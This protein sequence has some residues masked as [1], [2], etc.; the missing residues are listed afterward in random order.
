MKYFKNRIFLTAVFC[1]VILSL[2]LA[3]PERFQPQVYGSVE[4]F[5]D[6]LNRVN[7]RSALHRAL[8][9]HDEAYAQLSHNTT[10]EFPV[11]MNYL[12]WHVT[13]VLVVDESSI[14]PKIYET[15]DREAGPGPLFYSSAPKRVTGAT[16]ICG[17]VFSGLIPDD[18]KEAVFDLQIGLSAK[19][20]ANTPK[21]KY[22]PYNLD[23][24][25]PPEREEQ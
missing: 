1:T 8:N 12:G 9:G 25:L 17:A 11:L 4:E 22:A 24:S 3:K 13:W 5:S 14:P 15:Y 6:C 21:Q 18:V 10:D 7:K 2:V 19:S 16:E 23:F 20:T